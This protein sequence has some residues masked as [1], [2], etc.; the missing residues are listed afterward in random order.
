MALATRSAL[1]ASIHIPAASFGASSSA[2]PNPYPL[3]SPNA[4][5]VD[6]SSG[7]S[8]H[9]LYVTDPTNFRIE[10]FDAAG[11]FVSMF[12]KEVNKTKTEASAS[13]AEENL[14]TAA[15]GNECKSGVKGA[16]GKGEFSNPAFV[17]V[18]GST[19]AS[20]GDVY[21]GDRGTNMVYK[22][23]ANG[24]FVSANNGEGAGEGP[25]IGIDGVAV[26]TSG[27]LS[28]LDQHGHVV[29]FSQAGVFIPAAFPT[30]GAE[31]KGLAVD[32][33]GASYL[34]EGLEAVEKL[35]AGGNK[36]GRVALVPFEGG[37][38]TTGLAADQL[39]NDLYL[40]TGLEI[41]HIAPSCD[42]S[43]GLCAIADTFG[44][45][46]LSAGEG[47]AVDDSDGTVYVADS[48]TGTV[49]R[50]IVGLE[51]NTGPAGELGASTATIAAGVNPEGSQVS[52]CVFEYGSSEEYGQSAP[53]E[54]VVGSGSASVSVHAKLKGLTGGTTYHFRIFAKNTNGVVRGEDET[55][56]TLTTPTIDEASATNVTASSAELTAKIN[57]KGIDTK[58]RFEYGTSTAYGTSIPIPDADIGSGSSDVAVSQA[59][60][61]LGPNTTYHFRVLLTDTHGDIVTGV[62]HTFVFLAKKGPAGCVNEAL[63]SGLAANLPDC[64]GYEMV[65][66]PQ[67]NGALI[68]ALFLG[69]VAPQ[70]SSDGSRVTVPSIQCFGG[71]KSCTASRQNEGEPYEFSRTSGS[72]QTNPLAPPA[73][74]FQTE[75]WWSLGANAGTALF[76][77]PSPPNGQDDFYARNADGSF[78]QIGPIGEG[79]ASFDLVSSGVM[80]SSA[81][82]S[83]VVY[84]TAMPVWSFDAGKS[85]A[86]S[87]YEYATASGALPQLV[88]VS[89]GLESHDL[90][91]TCGIFV[92]GASLA[93]STAY[94]S[95]STDGREIYFTVSPCAS[96]SGTNTGKATLQNELYERIDSS[97]TVQVSVGTSASCTTTGCKEAPASDA[98]FEGASNDG[99]KVFFTSTQQLSDEASQDR[100]G[101]DSA[102][103][104]NGAVASG[105][106]LYESECP[107]H[108]EDL[109]QRKL[110]DVSAGAQDSGGPKVQGTTAISP[111]GSHVYFVAKGV[112]TTTKNKE[113]R[114]AQEGANNL[115]LYE[116]DEAQPSGKLS[117]VATLAPGDRANW[118]N[119]GLDQGLGIANTTPD[120]RYLVLE[121]HRG[122]TPD[123]SAGEGPAQI[124]RYDAS[125]EA[126]T[127]ISRGQA[128]FSDN[129][130]AGKGGAD[131]SIDPAFHAFI[132]G[133]GPARANPT[134]SDDGRY[135][136]F[137]SPLA[138]TP[139]ALNEVKTGGIEPSGAQELAKNVY[140]WEA[141]GTGKCEEAEGCVSLI[142]DGKDTSESGKIAIFSPELLGT[143]ATGENVFLATNSQLTGKD[144]DSQR[145]YYDARIGGG[146]EP[147]VE[148]IKCRGCRG[149]AST[150]PPSGALTSTLIG[151]SGNFA[152]LPGGASTGNPGASTNNTKPKP[153][154][155][156]QQLARALRTCRV[157]RDKSK[158]AACER[159]AR[160]KFGPKAKSKSSHPKKRRKGGGR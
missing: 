137:E 24:A 126:M 50:F 76:S 160:R 132:L 15:S 85:N 131:A 143:D 148:P 55:F 159:Q 12:G 44:F 4:V 106:N 95:L 84:G 104:C 134:M 30:E 42:P 119:N 37:P 53:C 136:F 141:D 123:A 68:G 86:P 110:I 8:A 33:S 149:P 73:S 158:R 59:I 56:K 74:E 28:V 133:N 113:G 114:G 155:K 78:S 13:E 94:G 70:V 152:P 138:L 5:A 129:G 39:S 1:A 29:R 17:A 62:D 16:G 146:E 140:E 96:G 14:C 43:K 111:D 118:A 26:D 125:A 116:R 109:A 154:S 80:L 27:N 117:F 115:Y 82:L 147:V 98:V 92:G 10:K 88:G 105:C 124:Y 72:W 135:V 34:V 23:S 156:A 145:D 79:S 18:D 21:I 51:A 83:H 47:V 6:R 139:G 2:P 87:L 69:Q 54:E 7:S 22:F 66:P 77:M 153:L 25:F 122:L 46:Q 61:G 11:N 31:P 91:G 49:D 60:E 97:R 67:K 65:T 9:D 157:K 130:N 121:S 127:R 142:S 99:S 108:C 103:S 32:G 63:R 89:G 36:V 112:L 3:G 38:P 35:D 41:E 52:E 90:L 40:D 128:G 100:H 151:P 150:P 57:P 19:G 20:S 107:N 102:E 71:A 64:R 93:P 48:A 45:P 81:D 101:G 144:T 75:T 58:Y 120:G